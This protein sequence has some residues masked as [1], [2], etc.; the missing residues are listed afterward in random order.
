M[1]VLIKSRPR[2]IK[3][4]PRPMGAVRRLIQGL[5]LGLTNEVSK[6]IVKEISLVRGI[7]VEVMRDDR[8]RINGIWS[9]SVTDNVSVKVC[10]SRCSARARWKGE[11]LTCMRG[12]S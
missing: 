5:I 4:L 1:L 7:E 2:N 12:Y 6:Q 3:R 9:V 8:G 10:K 11:P